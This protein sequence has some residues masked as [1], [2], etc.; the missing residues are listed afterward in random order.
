MAQPKR[1]QNIVGCEAHWKQ[2]QQ[3]DSSSYTRIEGGIYT[4]ETKSASIIPRLNVRQTFE[5]SPGAAQG[6]G[7][8]GTRYARSDLSSR[9]ALIALYQI[10]QSRLP[11]PKLR[12]ESACPCPATVHN[13]LRRRPLRSRRWRKRRVRKRKMRTRT[14]AR[15]RMRIRIGIKT[16]LGWQGRRRGRRGQPR[17]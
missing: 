9:L 6:P 14:R 2:N 15:M 7:N 3:R 8:R 4:R 12:L 16:G 17:C 10:A 11:K 1:T 5:Q 13:R